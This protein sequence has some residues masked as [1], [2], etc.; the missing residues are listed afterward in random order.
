MAFEFLDNDFVFDVNAS[1]EIK[2]KFPTYSEF[3]VVYIIYSQHSGQAYIGES[4]NIHSRIKQHLANDQKRNLKNIKVIF[5]HY[6][7]KSSVLDIES[8]LIK[9]MAADGTYRLLNA[10]DGIS[11][12]NYYQ[13]QEYKETFKKIWHEFKLTNLV[14][15]DLLDIENS[16]LFKFSPYKKLS[17]DQFEV[18][19]NYL[20]LITSGKGKSVFFEGSAGTGKTILAIYL[21][22]LLLNDAKEDD[23]K[24]SSD[25]GSLIELA[26][27]A[28]S[29]IFKNLDE[30]KI[31][32]VVPVK[33]LRKT[34][35]RVF[36]SIHGLSPKMVIGANEAPKQKEKYDLL[37]V[38]ESHR[39][40]RRKN[41]VGY[42]SFDNTNQLLGLDKYDGTELDWVVMSSYKSVF[43]YDSMQSIKPSDISKEKFDSVIRGSDL[44]KISSQ[45]R[46][47]GGED[48]IEFVD[49]L[50]TASK[51]LE[52]W[53]SEGYEL[54]LFSDIRDFVD[55]LK[56][57]EAEHG[58]CRT[59]SGYSWEWVSRK[60]INQPDLTI[61]GIDF[62]WNKTDEDWI[63]S[64]SDVLEMGCIHTTQGY[65]LNYAGIIFGSDITFDHNTQ[66]I[67]VIEANY[68]DKKG[69][70]GVVSDDL[71]NYIINIY[72][73][74]M[75]RGIKGTFVYCYDKDLEKYFKQYI[76]NR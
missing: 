22:K 3:P 52:V 7:N 42:G 24:D 1:I 23:L 8:S 17:K 6:F 37:I 72:K 21:I 25:N 32:L 29:V 67:V 57:K 50:L 51:D 48:Y 49:K 33:S 35:K 13:R 71:H 60:E 41:L 9:Y 5:S 59:I 16:D 18:L 64:T 31:A 69:K 73:T 65:D 63:N 74:I 12:H 27:K 61:D 68:H 75:Y 11:E 45:M 66:R 2:S 4:T 10:N 19:K 26:N 40:K 54:T 20:E 30:P 58:L 15:T 46:V 28:K 36:K 38:D 62:F 44:L 55:Q 14:K 39:L 56:L 47:K 76:S 34:L 53:N 70:A 43:F